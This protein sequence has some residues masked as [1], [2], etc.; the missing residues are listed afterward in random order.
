MTTVLQASVR[1]HQVIQTEPSLAPALRDHLAA[2]PGVVDASR[3][4]DSFDAV[5]KIEVA[6][7]GELRRVLAASRRAPGLF[8]LCLCCAAQGPTASP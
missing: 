5:A 7:E 8:R 3:T 4:T 1:A 6:N 2:I